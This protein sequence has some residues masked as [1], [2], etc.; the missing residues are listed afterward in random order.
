MK[1]NNLYLISICLGVI[2]FCITT[3]YK[4]YNPVKKSIFSDEK[5][6][7][8][9]FANA[10]EF[11]VLGSKNE[12][13]T[14]PKKMFDIVDKCIN[15]G[16][17]IPTGTAISSLIIIKNHE[18]RLKA[19]DVIRKFYGLCIKSKEGFSE[20]SK[21]L[22]QTIFANYASHGDR[23]MI[24][25][26]MNDSNKDVANIAKNAISEDDDRIAKGIIVK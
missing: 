23:E 19:L 18:D 14:N 16:K 10:Q 1:K 17:T 22:I 2:A 12:W 9:G 13:D 4:F 11:E 25:K 15:T 3:L 21:G 26:L 24:S 20:G 6:V 8:Q 5:A 7:S